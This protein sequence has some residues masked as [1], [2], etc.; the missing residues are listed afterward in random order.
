MSDYP[1]NLKFC[2][3]CEHA[4]PEGRN[5]YFCK[6]NFMETYRF[7]TCKHWKS[8]G[9]YYDLQY[10]PVGKSC[11]NLRK[12]NGIRY[13]RIMNSSVRLWTCDKCDSLYYEQKGKRYANKKP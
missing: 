9:D 2:E 6:K 13:C 11:K 7:E 12:K 8:N 1:E 10:I 4:R 5:S 3:T